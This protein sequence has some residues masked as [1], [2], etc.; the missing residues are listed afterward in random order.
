MEG[1]RREEEWRMRGR[2]V[3]EEERLGQRGASTSGF[4]VSRSFH[5]INLTMCEA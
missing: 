1:G 4:I 5:V 3:V 2:S